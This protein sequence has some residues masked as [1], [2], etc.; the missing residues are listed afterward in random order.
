MTIVLDE[1]LE[2]IE[3]IETSL[4]DRTFDHL[5]SEWLLR[6]G[7]ERAIEILSEAS[8]H[9]PDDLVATEPDI[10]WKRVR[11]VGN[12]LR[13]EYHRIAAEVIWDLA[14]SDLPTLKAAL[15]RFRARI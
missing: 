1:M 11:G 4:A 8:R 9:L 15:I 10:P 12:V 7:I 3:R 2:T 14:I 5:A 13:H 6:M